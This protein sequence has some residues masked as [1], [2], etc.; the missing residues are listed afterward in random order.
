MELL[1]QWGKPMSHKEIAT[2]LGR[3]G[4]SVRMMVTKLVHTGEVLK[5]DYG[6]YSVNVKETGGV[7][8]TLF[9]LFTPFTVANTDEPVVLDPFLAICVSGS[10]IKKYIYIIITKEE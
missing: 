1:Q 6:K 9:T 10:L 8:N 4:T 3:D 7:S 2:A 5:S